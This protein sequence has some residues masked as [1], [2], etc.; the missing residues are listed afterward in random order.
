MAGIIKSVVALAL[1]GAVVF[2]ASDRFK[3][4]AVVQ[5]PM[6]TEATATKPPTTDARP[7]SAIDRTP[8]AVFDPVTIQGGGPAAVQQSD[9]KRMKEAAGR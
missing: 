1:G 7:R 3:R 9:L 8:G 5:A 6:P 2:W 4:P